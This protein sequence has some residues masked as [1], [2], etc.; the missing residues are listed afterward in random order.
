MKKYRITLRGK[1]VIFFI[2]IIIVS[3]VAL[4]TFKICEYFDSKQIKDNIHSKVQYQNK[5]KMKSGTANEKETNKTFRIFKE[6]SECR[7]DKA[8]NSTLSIKVEDAYKDDGEKIAFLTF[9]D[10][11]SRN[12]TP[13]LLKILE[14]NNVK[15]TFFLIGCYC[16]EYPDLVRDIY[17]KGNAI[18]IHT[19][20]HKYSIIYGQVKDF[21]YEVEKNKESLNNI[22]GSQFK[23]RIFRFPGGSFYDFRAPFREEVKKEGY[24][25]I[26]WNATS[27]DG[28]YNGVTP[29]EQINNLKDSVKG[30][31]HVVILMH[32]S[33]TKDTT[34]QALPN[35]L[36]YIK[37]EGY[38]FAILE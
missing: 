29:E 24:A 9:D 6:Y 1:I 36:K 10:G 23:T 18:G 8:L 4:L 15:A 26:D 11:P 5:G 12:V 37:N 25:Y 14:D 35:L 21:K 30:K 16:D 19:Y 3:I 13:K 28:E 38:K 34:V 7:E 27:G 17:S 32:N 2:I 31:N 20:T 33:A 22:L